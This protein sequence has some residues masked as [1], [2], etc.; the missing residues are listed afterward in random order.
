MSAVPKLNKNRS[1]QTDSMEDGPMA[2]TIM[3]RK[4][5]ATG[6]ESSPRSDGNV[7]SNEEGSAPKAV[8]KTRPPA[9]AKSSD[10]GNAAAKERTPPYAKESLA[11][12]GWAR[13]REQARKIHRSS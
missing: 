6:M 10:K 5:A 7:E 13:A 2:V 12:D 3:I 9:P 11:G 4:A 1:G 8:G